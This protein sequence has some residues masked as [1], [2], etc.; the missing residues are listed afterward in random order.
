MRL[1]GAKY[2]P[3]QIILIPRPIALKFNSFVKHHCS[4][5]L[6]PTVSNRWMPVKFGLLTIYRPHPRL[7]IPYQ[8]R[9]E[10][11]IHG[12][13][14]VNTQRAEEG[15]FFLGG[16][17]KG[18][19]KEHNFINKI[20]RLMYLSCVGCS[21]MELKSFIIVFVLNCFEKSFSMYQLFNI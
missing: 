12:S 17:S 1:S 7:E 14:R 13:I 21:F 8:A 5:Y 6:K 11:Q 9:L 2:T 20:Y 16:Q 19:K 4:S 15:S 3:Y 10:I 18:L